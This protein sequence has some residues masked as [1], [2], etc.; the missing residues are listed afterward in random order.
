MDLPYYAIRRSDS[1]ELDMPRKANGDILRHHEELSFLTTMDCKSKQKV[2]LYEAH[3]TCVVSGSHNLRWEAHAFLDTYYDDEEGIEQY[4]YDPEAADQLQVDPLRAGGPADQPISD[5]R[6]YFLIVLE[7]R[8]NRVRKEWREVYEGLDQLMKPSVSDFRACH[9]KPFQTISIL[10]FQAWNVSL[11]TMRISVDS[12][13]E[14]HIRNYLRNFDPLSF[15]MEVRDCELRLG[16]VRTW[17]DQTTELLRRLE[18]DLSALINKWDDFNCVQD[19]HFGNMDSSVQHCLRAIQKSFLQL[20]GITKDFLILKGRCAAIR[21]TVS[22][23]QDRTVLRKLIDWDFYST[24]QPC[25]SKLRQ[26]QWLL[27]KRRIR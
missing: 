25:N 16:D 5:P 19:Y 4:E 1:P 2:F 13:Q 11:S 17:V 20:R 3:F 18:V 27:L 10:H 12:V 21:E 8:I 14:A 9:H 26:N 15:T 22:G 23:V 7:I 24:P 6:Q